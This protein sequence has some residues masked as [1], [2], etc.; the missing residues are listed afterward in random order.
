MSKIFG[1]LF[2]VGGSVCTGM[3]CATKIEKYNY[4]ECFSYIN[5]IND[6][7]QDQGIPNRCSV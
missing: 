3:P 1:L 6:R 7:I 2:N 5:A 4:S